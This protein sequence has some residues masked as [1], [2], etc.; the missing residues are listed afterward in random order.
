VLLLCCSRFTGQPI[1]CNDGEYWSLTLE[2]CAGCPAGKFGSEDHTK[3]SRC[4]PG[5]Y[6]GISRSKECTECSAGSMTDT[7]TEDSAQYCI[8][9]QSGRY[10]ENSQ[11]VRVARVVI[12]R[13]GRLL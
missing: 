11:L 10:T 12:S 5:F 9:C 2:T 3:C 8:V 7:G 4:D 6:T 1:T 13:K